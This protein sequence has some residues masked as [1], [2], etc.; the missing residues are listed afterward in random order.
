MI[1]LTFALN[2]ILSMLLLVYMTLYLIFNSF[3]EQTKG[4]ILV[5]LVT[6]NRGLCGGYNSQIIKKTLKK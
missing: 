2:D 5:V 4:E 3:N 1:E 6:S